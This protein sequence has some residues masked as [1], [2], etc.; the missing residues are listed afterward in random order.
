MLL[1]PNSS[2]LFL[3]K[4][5]NDIVTEDIHK[6][7]I[8]TYPHSHYIEVVSDVGRTVNIASDNFGTS[9]SRKLT[10]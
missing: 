1:I 8:K 3:L 5:H 9:C 7:S 10:G 2:L 6:I 4:P